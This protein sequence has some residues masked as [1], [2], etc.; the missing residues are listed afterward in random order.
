M[1]PQQALILPPAEYFKTYDIRG[2]VGSDGLTQT[3]VE[4]LGGAIA[5]LARQ[6][7]QTTLVVGRDVRS[8]G[9]ALQEALTRGLLQAG[10][11]VIDIGIVSTP[12]MYFAT[13]QL[14]TLA[15]VMV[16]ASHNPPEYNGFKMVLA[17]RCLTPEE[18]QSL[19]MQSSPVPYERPGSYSKHGIEEAYYDRVLSDVT[20]KRKMKVVVDCGNG[21]V[22]R[23][24]PELIKRLGCEVIPLY[25]EF[26]GQ[27]PNHMPDPSRS[28]NLL[29]L[30]HKVQSEGADL[31][32][33]FDGDGDRLAVVDDHGC[34]I[35]PDRLIMVYAKELLS[36]QPGATILID[37][38]SSRRIIDYVEQLGGQVVMWKSG[39]SLMKEKMREMNIPFGGELSGHM[40]FKDR[41]YGFDDGLY[42]AS[43]LLEIL[44][45]VDDTAHEFFSAFPE[46]YFTPEILVPV[47]EGQAKGIIERMQS[48]ASEFE[49]EALLIDGLRVD[50][51]D[52]WGLVRASNTMPYLTMRFEA[53]SPS[54]LLAIQQKFK[55]RL[56][57]VCPTLDLPF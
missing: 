11:D 14:R 35:L 13:Y 57:A 31:G 21:A 12:V 43:R 18:I 41:W 51:P 5:E 30:S 36:R 39:H 40:F 53:E 49:G 46:G 27:F 28:E 29:A 34:I 52:G 55:A 42:A 17:G 20:L 19:L 48:N 26:D 6:F 16:T 24:A 15:G 33:A 50:Y 25:C 8:S 56:V 32:I 38:K 4:G 45:A 23:L 22:S 37:V 2:I 54:A 3:N 10:C 1:K 9:Q 47:L 44:S 7:G